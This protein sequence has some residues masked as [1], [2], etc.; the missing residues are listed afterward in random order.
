[1][2]AS[3]STTSTTTACPVCGGVIAQA[4]TGRPARYCGTPCRQ[5]AHRARR[6]VGEAETQAAWLR[7]R[8]VDELDRLRTLSAELEAALT[9]VTSP[10]QDDDQNDDV[11][12]LQ[13]VLEGLELPEPP[14]DGRG[15][16]DGLP[17]GW[18]PSVSDLARRLATLASTIAS[19]A[20]QHQAAVREWEYAARTAGIRR[21]PAAASSG[22]ETSTEHR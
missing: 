17:T 7:G 5:A 10:A 8:L 16:D 1:M 2:T 3:P 19:D 9:A 22:D 12:A 15:R 21:A 14:Q 20:R 13:D 6:R 11:T 18:E 4:A